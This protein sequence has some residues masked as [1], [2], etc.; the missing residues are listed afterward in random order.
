MNL[1]FLSLTIVTV[2]LATTVYAQGG[3]HHGGRMYNPA[4][5]TTITGTVDEIKNIPSQG[6]GGGG[7]H[8]VLSAPSGAIDVRVGPASFVSSKGFTFAKG[9]ALTVVGSKVTMTGQEVL[10]AREIKKGEQVLTLRDAKGY[11]LW[12]GRGRSQPATTP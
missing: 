10:I 2:G 8:L 4:T 5:E 12:S 9:D 7:L 11:P 6:R 3:M 1:K